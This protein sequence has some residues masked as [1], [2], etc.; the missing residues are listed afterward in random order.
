MF[1]KLLIANRGEIACRIA[2]TARRMGIRTVAIYSDIDRDSLHVEACDEAIAIGGTSS[3]DSYLKI[4]KVLNA[5]I[6]T[7]SDAIHPGYGFLS[8][9]SKLAEEC[10]AAK[11]IFVGPP[12]TAIEVMGS[13]SK[14]KKLMDSAG[15]PLVPGYHGEEQEIP[16]LSKKA[17]EIGFPIL[18]K[19]SAGGGG[20]GMR[21]VE[22]LNELEAA[23][24]SSKREAKAA[25]SNDHLMLEKFITKPRHIEV[26][27]F[28]DE[29]GNVVHLFER[30]CS[31]QRRYQ[32]VIEEAPAPNLSIE[33]R[34]KLFEA[35]L[36]AVRAVNY[37]GAGTIEFIADANQ[38]YFIEMNTRLQVEH[39]VT[40]AISGIDLVEWQ[41]RIASGERLPLRQEEITQNGHAIE[42][43]L[44]AEDPITFQP[45]AG[46]IKHLK[47]PFDKVRVD[48]AV[49]SGDA[50]SIYYDPMISKL[51]AHDAT[52][53]L[54][55]S[56]LLHAIEET[57]IDGLVSNR[58]FLM[59]VLGHP[60]FKSAHLHTGFVE[61]NANSLLKP[62]GDPDQLHQALA[63]VLLLKKRFG[64]HMDIDDTHNKNSS[65]WD[66]KAGWR[67]NGPGLFHIDLSYNGE[68]KSFL[69]SIEN[70]HFQILRPFKTKPLMPAICWNSQNNGSLLL[71]METK[72]KSINFYADFEHVTFF[73]KER[74]LSFVS[75]RKATIS[76]TDHLDEKS[77]TAPMPAKIISVNV[78]AGT[79]VTAGTILVILEAMKIENPIRAT[80]SGVVETVFFAEGDIVEEGEILLKFTPA[81]IY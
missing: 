21:I 56:K 30:D 57:E 55:R 9:N 52:R 40:E 39:S 59:H 13:K 15:V 67:V 19:A 20:R 33:M 80:K 63:V 28:A 22:S 58:Q 3:A 54:A 74:T 35:A 45:Q 70:K 4:D 69:L 11:I 36:A 42:A 27:I 49:R 32:K 50:V 10:G 37:V 29:K 25:F 71:S 48:T 5:A 26:Q 77:F 41:I 61:E 24:S 65:P 78:H 44:Y 38:F 17:N 53:E 6:E 2:S 31:V 1:E 66:E 62:N 18:V 23:V 79:E 8:E 43:R 76:N 12:A 68:K 14:A 7:E 34:K 75:P 73:L 46:V 72:N 64:E 16:Y 47:L 51:T 60:K 81:E